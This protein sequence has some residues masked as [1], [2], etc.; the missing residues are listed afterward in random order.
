MELLLTGLV[1]IV[2]SVAIVVIALPKARAGSGLTGIGRV[3]DLIP[4][5]VLSLAIIGIALTTRALV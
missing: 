4:V 2:T 5:A 3:D 1:C